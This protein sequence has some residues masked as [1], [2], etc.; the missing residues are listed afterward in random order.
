[1]FCYD[2]LHPVCRA[3]LQPAGVC[4]HAAER[5][6]R[7]PHLDTHRLWR[8]CG[9]PIGGC[10]LRSRPA[11]CNAY[12][13]VDA[14]LYRGIHLNPYTYLHPNAD[15]RSQRN[16]HG[17]LNRHLDADIHR[18]EHRNVYSLSNCHLYGYCHVY[19]H[20][21]E[22]SHR[23]G[24]SDGNALSNANFHGYVDVHSFSNEYC[25]THAA[26]T[27]YSINHIHCHIH[28]YIDPFSNADVY[29]KQYGLTN[30]VSTAS[31]RFPDRA[32]VDLGVWHFEHHPENL[33]HRQ[34]EADN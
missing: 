9:F 18:D 29:P 34:R 12:P 30:S 10:L 8:V 4:V 13:Y 26:P 20:P 11:D 5:T 1:M 25:H 23:N 27:F 21:N 19:L 22:H 32:L 6:G 16:I 2:D 28:F 33:P 15:R 31:G 24:D 17:N 14:D 3:G 7:L